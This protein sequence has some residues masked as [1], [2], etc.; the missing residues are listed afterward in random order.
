MMILKRTAIVAIV[1]ALI[2]VMLHYAAPNSIPLSASIP[3][4]IL[5]TGIAFAMEN[6]APTARAIPNR[7]PE[8]REMV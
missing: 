6:A 4:C 3:V 7:A 8:E 5:L 1:F 2:V